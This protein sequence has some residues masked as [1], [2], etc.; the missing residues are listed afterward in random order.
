MQRHDDRNM[1]PGRWKLAGLA[2]SAGWIVGA[3]IYLQYT[4]IRAAKFLRN[5]AFEICDYVSHRLI[6]YANC[7]ADLTKIAASLDNVWA[8]L[9]LLSLAPVLFVWLVAYMVQKLW[10]WARASRR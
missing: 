3:A 8:S 9:A 1:R 7:W 10:Q 4:D 5:A 6:A 2:A